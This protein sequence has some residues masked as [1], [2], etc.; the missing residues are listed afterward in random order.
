MI[1]QGVLF[2][3]TASGQTL[4]LST[5]SHIG[6]LQSQSGPP[7]NPITL[8]SNQPQQHTGFEN[9]PVTQFNHT[10]VSSSSVIAVLNSSVS[11][12]STNVNVSNSI[13]TIPVT[14]QLQSQVMTK[15]VAVTANGSHAPT[16]VNSA[17]S[18][19]GALMTQKINSSSAQ[20][21]HSVSNASLQEQSLHQVQH[22]GQNVVSV[23]QVQAQIQQQS[24]SG[25]GLAPQLTTPFILRSN[26][27]D[28]MIPGHI[29]LGRGMQGTETLSYES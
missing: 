7:L 11:T 13:S 19:T 16:L 21:S 24:T 8:Q 3:Q 1:S 9:K 5:G 6:N 17:V 25:S 12:S 23:A 22:L 15:K 10:N 4:I 29:S 18:T 20:N 26:Q 2:G 14:A 28:F 27:G